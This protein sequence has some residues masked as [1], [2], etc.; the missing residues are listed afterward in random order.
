MTS[1]L[2]DAGAQAERTALAWR[3]TGLG[4]LGVG[5]LLL[6]SGGD[7]PPA[8]SLAVGLADVGT[9]AVLATVVAAQRYRRTLTAVTAG[10]TP[11]ASRACQ[12][13]TACALAT[14]LAAAVELV[15]AL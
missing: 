4:L 6:H 15:A 7:A 8:L 5:A 2:Y 11:L 3:R 1:A 12:A 10:R 13:T 14:A 9:G